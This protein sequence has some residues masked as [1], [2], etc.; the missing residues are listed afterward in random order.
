GRPPLFF[1]ALHG[2]P[3]HN[4]STRRTKWEGAGVIYFIQN[5]VSKAIKIGYSKDPR[6]RL[7]GLQSTTP[8]RLELLGYI[9]GGLEHERCYH[10]KFEE[11]RLQREWFK[12][13]ILP[14]VL[15]IIAQNP[16]DRPP[17]SNVLVIGD[18]DFRDQP[19]LDRT[20]DELHA[21]NRIAWVVTA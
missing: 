8:D 2:E 14:L 9:H 16:L 12:P 4:A 11:Y 21:K 20:L 17:P 7:I 15:E 13:I 3:G 10:D 1:L 18:S 19:L 5:T 6:K